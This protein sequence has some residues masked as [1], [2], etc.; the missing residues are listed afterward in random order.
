LT[1]RHCAS[2]TA[3]SLDSDSLQRTKRRKAWPYGP[4]PPAAA[5]LTAPRPPQSVPP[6]DQSIIV[7]Q[8]DNPVALSATFLSVRNL[9]FPIGEKHCSWAPDQSDT[10]SAGHNGL[11]RPGDILCGGVP[12]D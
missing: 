6:S 11:P 3:F 8:L 12:A 10:S 4:P 1:S 5:G 9:G 2:S 7:V